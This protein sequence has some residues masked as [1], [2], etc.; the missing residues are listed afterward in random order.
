MK[1]NKNTGKNLVNSNHP[2]R[3]SKNLKLTA[4]SIMLCTLTF[5]LAP[6]TDTLEFQVEEKPTTINVPHLGINLAH[7]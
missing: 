7:L 6:A 4:L 2:N 5:S 1:G 3:I